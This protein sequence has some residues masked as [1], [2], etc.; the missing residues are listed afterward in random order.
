MSISGEGRS[1]PCSKETGASQPFPLN[2]T[3]TL[4]RRHLAQFVITKYRDKVQEVALR[5]RIR[6]IIRQVCKELGVQ[7]VS[8]I[9]SREHVHMLVEIP[10]HHPVS[11]FMRR[12]K[13]RS[14]RR[15]Q[16]EF[17]DASAPGDGISGRAASLST[18][19][20]NITDDVI[21]QYLP[22]AAGR[23]SI[24]T[25][26]SGRRTAARSQA[27]AANLAQARRERQGST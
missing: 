13:G 18:T 23:Y 25:S 12:V 16:R 3:G 27:N 8:G 4:S 21:H 7:I 15:L 22:A 1:F 20:G 24:T 5:K 9:L 6:T 17:P 10:P 14:S 11:D 26:K 2:P 19:S